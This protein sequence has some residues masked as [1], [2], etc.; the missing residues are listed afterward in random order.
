MSV[1]LGTREKHGHSKVEVRA[2]CRS[3]RPQQNVLRCTGLQRTYFTVRP[4]A[5]KWRPSWSDHLPQGAIALI[6]EG[7]D[8]DQAFPAS[9]E[10]C[11][12]VVFVKPS[13]C[14]LLGPTLCSQPWSRFKLR[15]GQ[16][17]GRRCAKVSEGAR[18]QESRGTGE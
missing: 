3:T 15:F 11:G 13:C 12:H 10:Q 4:I 8:L 18:M 9:A 14:N 6:R 17:I 1:D 16:G 7:D 5:A 2:F